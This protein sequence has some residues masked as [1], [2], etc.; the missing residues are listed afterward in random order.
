MDAVSED[1]RFAAAVAAFGQKLRGSIHAAMSWDAI[2]DL[3]RDAR[4]EDEGGYRSE[5]L[6]LARTAALLKPDTHTDPCQS[7]SEGCE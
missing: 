3:A 1:F 7:S 6:N 2:I 4:G 5:F